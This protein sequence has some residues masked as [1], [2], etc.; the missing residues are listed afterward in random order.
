MFYMACG[1]AP[2]GIETSTC[3]MS[4]WF[5]TNYYYI[6]PEFTT[7]QN[8]ELCHDDLF[9]S[10]KLALENNYRAKP[11]ILGPLSFLCLGKCKGGIV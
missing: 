4:K 5:D 11:V 3:K 10:T 2:N 6:A 9:K 8:F 7:N 1:Q